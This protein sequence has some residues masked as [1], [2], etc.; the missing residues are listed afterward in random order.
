MHK[1][2]GF[3]SFS[4]ICL[5]SLSAMP[6]TAYAATSSK[7]PGEDGYIFTN[8]R[9][10]ATKNPTNGGFVSHSAY[11]EDSAYIAPTAAVCNSASVLKYARI[12]GKAIVSDEAEITD[13]ARVYGN[14]RVSGTAFV[15]GEAK[16][17]DH[18]Q[19]SGEAIV[20]GVT[21]VR[22]YTKVNSGLITKGTISAKK[23]QALIMAE[24][25]AA[26]EYALDAIVNMMTEGGDFEFQEKNDGY[27]DDEWVRNKITKTSDVCI[28]AIHQSYSY[29]RDTTG[30]VI[31]DNPTIKH[32]QSGSE[33]K[34]TKEYCV[35]KSTCFYSR[36]DAERLLNMMETYQNNYCK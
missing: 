11:V 29:K 14:A 28:L 22:G 4:L 17:S 7:C 24:A 33:F 1:T 26:R 32:Y 16:V 10:H 35:Y 15:G 5:F 13:K 19:V 27:W 8:H 18:A 34:T 23:T 20:E 3:F 21:W 2:S 31:F 12:Y 30:E 9:G 6:V 36:S 25:A